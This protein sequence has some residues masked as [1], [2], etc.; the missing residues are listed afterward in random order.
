MEQK[1]ACMTLF[2]LPVQP[3]LIII[4]VLQSSP[5]PFKNSQT[6][7]PNCW[8]DSGDGFSINGSSSQERNV[9]RNMCGTLQLHVLYLASIEAT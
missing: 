3:E 5:F 2:P 1:L 6:H 7:I 8:T 4:L 9:R